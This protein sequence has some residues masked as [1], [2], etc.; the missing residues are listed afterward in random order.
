MIFQLKFKL[1]SGHCLIVFVLLLLISCAQVGSPSG[2]AKDTTPPKIVKS[3]PENFS[4][5]FKGNSLTLVFDE[6]VQVKDLNSQLIISPPLSKKPIIKQKGKAVIFQFNEDLLDSTTYTFNLGKSI[7]DLNEG[8]ILDSNLFVFST[9]NFLDS[10][11]VSGFI[12]NAADAKPEKDIAVM[13][14][15]NVKDSVYYDNDFAPS[16]RDSIPY[17]NQPLYLGRT[18]E[19]GSFAI[20]NIKKGNYIIFALKDLNNNLLFDQPGELIAFSD[21]LMQIDTSNAVV[22]LNLFEEAQEKQYVKKAYAERYGKFTFVFNQ[23]VDSLLVTPS[24]HDFKKAWFLKESSANRDTVSYWLT[25]IEGMD[26]LTLI[27]NDYKNINDTFEIAIGKKELV[28]KDLKRSRVVKPSPLTLDASF[29]ATTTNLLDYNK[30]L[31]F[32]FSHPVADYDFSNV[33]LSSGV[34]TLSFKTKI[35]DDISRTFELIYPWVEDSSYNLFIPPGAFVDIFN[36]G[37]D[38]ITNSFKVNSAE[39]YGSILLSITV[40]EKQH[41]FIIELS[42]DKNMVR[43]MVIN[44]DET[45][46]FTYLNPG[47]YNLKITYDEN[48]NEKWDTG[49]YLKKKQP[50]KVVYY[51]S[52]VTVRPNWDMELEWLVEG[53][54]DNKRLKE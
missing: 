16:Y 54:V 53:E 26:S 17:K 49:N 44:Q 33:V 41:Q 8:N 27:L 23:P 47:S 6:F 50:E 22:N 20:N 36:L 14:Y 5:E 31:I 35:V 2:G 48:N 40:P 51:S 46:E 52:G 38:T 19:D 37:N 29:N 39:S 9:G 25:D 42:K 3:I 34:D 12:K 11:R 30:N 32:E 1:I 43:K 10:L 13:L 21:S 4:T 15:A 18:K 24:S 7:V 45:V 28:N